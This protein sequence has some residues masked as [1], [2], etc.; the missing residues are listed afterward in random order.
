MGRYDIHTYNIRTDIATTSVTI[1]QS[2][3]LFDSNPTNVN[4]LQIVLFSS[5]SVNILYVFVIQLKPLA[6]GLP[7]KKPLAIVCK[8][9]LSSSQNLCKL[10]FFEVW[11]FMNYFTWK[12]FKFYRRLCH[13][14]ESCLFKSSSISCK[15]ILYNFRIQGYILSLADLRVT[16]R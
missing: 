12:D 4:S 15:Q 1:K 3:S 2:L 14:N 8:C 10:V 6:S 16:C 13:W 7:V 9:F 5:N 11:T